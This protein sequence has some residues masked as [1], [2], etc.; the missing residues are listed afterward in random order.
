VLNPGVKVPLAGQTALGD[1]KYDP[2][3]P[4]LPPRARAALDVVER[5]RAYDRFRLEL[6]AN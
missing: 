4:P 6:I 1:I 3:L 2:E 5:A